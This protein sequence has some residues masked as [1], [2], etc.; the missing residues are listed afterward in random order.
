[1]YVQLIQTQQGERKDK[2]RESM[3]SEY[4]CVV[5]RNSYFPPAGCYCMNPLQAGKDFPDAS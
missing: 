3:Y 4:F 2:K 1:M 5:P